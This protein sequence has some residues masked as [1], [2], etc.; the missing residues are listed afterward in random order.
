M[1]ALFVTATGTGVGKTWVTE[2]LIAECRAAR[3]PVNALKPVI[4]GFDPA[5]AGG[6]DSGRLLTALGRPIEART[7]DAISPWRFAAPLSPDMAAVREGR[8]I[9]FDAL[10]DVCRGAIEMTEG[11][12]LIEGVGGAMVPLDRR[13]TVRD[14]IAALGIPAVVVAGSYLGTISHSLT[15]LDSLAAGGIEAAAL[16]LSESEESPVPIA[17]TAATLARFTAVPILPVQR[18]EHV[19]GGAPLIAGLFP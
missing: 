13:H 15:T 16:V 8:T 4:S 5:D 6:S 14:W 17:E 9:D 11:L 12:L 2:R 3:R 1:S 10:I 7:L 19:D 18:D